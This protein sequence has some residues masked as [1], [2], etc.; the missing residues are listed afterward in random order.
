MFQ[1]EEEVKKIAEEILCMLVVDGY[2]IDILTK[3]EVGKLVDRYLQEIYDDYL[4]DNNYYYDSLFEEEIYDG[5]E[6][7]YKNFTTKVKEKNIH[8][9]EYIN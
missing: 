1:V 9:E 7:F 6:S 8:I 2:N 5:F 4:D 3:E